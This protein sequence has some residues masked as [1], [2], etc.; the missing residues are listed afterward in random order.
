MGVG[1]ANAEIARRMVVE[2]STIKWHVHHIYAKLQVNT[3]AQA[4]LRAQELGL[5][6]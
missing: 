3:R 4:I 5:F 2:T 6:S 1:L